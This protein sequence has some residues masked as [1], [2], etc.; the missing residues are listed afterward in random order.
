MYDVFSFCENYV[1]IKGL[2]K[3]NYE[4]RRKIHIDI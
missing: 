3:I 1:K 2:K 4:K